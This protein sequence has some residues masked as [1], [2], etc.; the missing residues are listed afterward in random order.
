MVQSTTKSEVKVELTV[1]ASGMEQVG[2]STANILGRSSSGLMKIVVQ[3]HPSSSSTKSPSESVV[4]SQATARTHTSNCP[5]N[6][7]FQ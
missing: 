5:Q 7:G 2:M 1:P 4:P 3:T 6:P